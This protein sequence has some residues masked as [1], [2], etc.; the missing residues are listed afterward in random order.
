MKAGLEE[1]LVVLDAV[2]G[3]IGLHLGDV[4]A[5]AELGQRVVASLLLAV[6]VLIAL[7]LVERLGQLADIVAVVAVLGELHRV[8]ALDDLE[9][10]RL[11][12]LGEL[13]DLVAGVVDVELAGHIGAGLLQHTGQ[14]VAQ[15]AAAGVAHV[16]GAGGVGGHELHHVLLPRQ[17]IVLTIMLADGLD[18]GDSVGIPLAAQTEVQEAGTRQ[19]HGG[20]VAA[21]QCHVVNE[22]LGHLTGVHLHGLGRGQTKRGG[23]VAVGGVL[24]DL[25]RRG[26]GNAGR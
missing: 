4:A 7:L 13:L 26:H 5:Q 15:H 14:R 1:P 23:I 18:A 2:A 11:Q 12:T 25:H 3:Q 10:A 9:I 16:H 8:L 24:G 19:L 17:H 21:L 6:Q 22:G 20:E